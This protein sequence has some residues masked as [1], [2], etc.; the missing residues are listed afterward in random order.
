M[1]VLPILKTHAENNDTIIIVQHSFQSIRKQLGQSH[2]VV[3]VDQP[4]ATKPKSLV[5]LG[6]L[7]KTINFFRTVDQH[8]ENGG[9]DDV[10]IEADVYAANSTKAMMAGKAYYWVLKGHTL[11]FE[12]LN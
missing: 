5:S 4:P 6:H 11:V 7:H 8:V 10:W 12:A 2:T 1:G 9:L 3:Y